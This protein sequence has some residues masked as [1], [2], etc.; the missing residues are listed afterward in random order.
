M[1]VKFE[2]KSVDFIVQS[3]RADEWISNYQYHVGKTVSQ[4]KAKDFLDKVFDEN[5]DE[6]HDDHFKGLTAWLQ[7]NGYPVETSFVKMNE[8]ANTPFVEVSDP[9]T[10]EDLVKIAIDGENEAIDVYRTALKEKAVADHPELAWMFSEFLK[11]EMNHLKELA[12]V[13]SQITGKTSDVKVDGDASDK[14]NEHDDDDV[15]QDADDDISDKSSEDAD[16]DE[17]DADAGTASDKDDDEDDDDED[18]EA[19][20]SVGEEPKRDEKRPNAQFIP[21]VNKVGESVVSKTE[22]NADSD[23]GQSPRA[24]GQQVI[25]E[26]KTHKKMGVIE[27]IMLKGMD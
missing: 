22:K 27:K 7:A 16:D 25:N 4:G 11:D 24:G 17:D 21:L 26:K 20:E 2:G 1:A 8:I 9:T 18:D 19:N 12:D 6:E 14:D 3:I 13:E 15:E 10:T 5:G 23:A